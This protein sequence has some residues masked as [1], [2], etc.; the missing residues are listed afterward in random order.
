MSKKPDLPR[1]VVDH[2][3]KDQM[4]EL[5]EAGKRGSEIAEFLES[6]GHP[7]LSAKTIGRYGQRNWNTKTTVTEDFS[8]ADLDDELR[9]VLADV[10]DSG[11]VTKFSYRRAVAPRL[12]GGKLVDAESTTLTAEIVPFLQPFQQAQPPIS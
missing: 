5:W 12:E 9:Q 4:R 10:G 6:A 11:T 1:G 2:P 8:S 3:A 7:V